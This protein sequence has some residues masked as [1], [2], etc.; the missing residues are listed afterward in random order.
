M[1]HMLAWRF[2]CSAAV[3][4]VSPGER[5]STIGRPVRSIARRIASISRSCSWYGRLMSSTLTKST[6]QEATSSKTE[7]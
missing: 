4:A 6:P 1:R 7:S 5:L 3:S 2:T